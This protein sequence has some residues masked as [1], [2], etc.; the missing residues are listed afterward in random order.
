VGECIRDHHRAPSGSLFHGV[1]DATWSL[2]SET[3]LDSLAKLGQ[4]SRMIGV[5]HPAAPG[6]L[7]R[8]DRNLNKE[9]VWTSFM[10]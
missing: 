10:S 9:S 6:C 5:Q 3:K 2:S 7:R 1:F 4:K 8:V